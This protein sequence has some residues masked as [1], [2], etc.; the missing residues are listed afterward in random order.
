MPTRVAEV[1]SGWCGDPWFVGA[2]MAFSAG[3]NQAPERRE[4]L[5][6]AGA[7]RFEQRLRYA[8]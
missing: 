5:V 3:H 1:P 4:Q 2:S 8:S 7:V 6:R